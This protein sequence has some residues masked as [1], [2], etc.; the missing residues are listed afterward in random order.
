MQEDKES[1]LEFLRHLASRGLA[2][3]RLVISDKCL[4]L[5]EAVHQ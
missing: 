5:V 1:W 2:G 3:V 4:G